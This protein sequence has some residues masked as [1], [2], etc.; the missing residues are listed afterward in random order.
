MKEMRLRL[1]TSIVTCMFFVLLLGACGKQPDEGKISQGTEK[2]GTD[3]TIE[4]TKN[5]K[6]TEWN[7]FCGKWI[8]AGYEYAD[9]IDDDKPSFDHKYYLAMDEW[10]YSELEIYKEEDRLYADYYSVGNGSQTLNGMTLTEADSSTKEFPAAQLKNR[11]NDED[12]IRKV[13]L[14][15]ENELC[16]S[17]WYEETE[18]DTGY[19]IIYTYLREESEELENVEDSQYLQEI[20][21]STIDELADA[22]QSRTKIILKEGEYNFSELDYREIQNANIDRIQDMDG[23]GE[24]TIQNVSNMSME[25]EEGASVV[26]STEVFYAKALDFLQGSYITLRGLTCGHEVEPGYCTGSVVCLS[27]CDNVRI[28]GCSLYGSGTYGVEAYNVNILTMD[29]T[30]VFDCTYGL[31]W[32]SEVQE[33][34]ITNCRFTDSDG[35]NMLTFWGCWSVLLDGC[36]ISGNN[37]EKEYATFINCQGSQSVSFIECTFRNN[38]YGVFLKDPYDPE[39]NTIVFTECTIDDGKPDF[40][41]P[42]G[43]TR[44]G[45]R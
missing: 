21:V 7:K 10:Q 24:Y 38:D 12:V 29:D 25:A 14:L 11:R 5:S 33:A 6:D 15:G 31:I 13:T 43:I 1:G 32:F 27:D 35:Y 41:Y 42:Q 3:S 9:S 4:D 19:M 18:W 45:N 17:E 30:D 16:Y 2:A 23:V 40:D 8:L 26:I 39:T 36:E 44:V 22:I 34:N 20:T 37:S 28:E